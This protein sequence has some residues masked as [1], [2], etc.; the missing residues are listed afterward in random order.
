MKRLSV[1]FWFGLFWIV[2]MAG[3]FAYTGLSQDAGISDP[4]FYVAIALFFMTM[5]IPFL[6]GFIA[7]QD[8]IK[9]K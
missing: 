5:A 1:F 8:W 2:G 6:T 7:G 9:R 4:I 3:T